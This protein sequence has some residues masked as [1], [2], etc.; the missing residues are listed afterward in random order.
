M[1]YCYQFFVF[2][3]GLSIDIASLWSSKAKNWKQGRKNQWTKLETW[4][5]E[6][7]NEN[8][9]WMHCASSGEYQQGK[10][11]LEKI[12]NR[13]AAFIAGLYQ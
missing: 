2:I 4:D 11:L 9:I 13:A 6:C 10:P 12:I 8:R 3:Y 5:N 1:K 7:K